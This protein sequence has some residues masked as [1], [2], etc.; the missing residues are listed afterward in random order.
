MSLLPINTA[1]PLAEPLL[2]EQEQEQEQERRSTD[3][4]HAE[5]YHGAK[6]IAL[7]AVTGFFIQIVSL[8][9]YAFLL[10]HYQPVRHIP[11]G[12]DDEEEDTMT[13]TT[14]AALMNGFLPTFEQQPQSMTYAFLSILTQV[15]LVVYV[16]IWVAFTC[17]M[18]RNGMTCIR[19]QF[20][21]NERDTDDDEEDDDEECQQAVSVKKR[22]NSKNIKRRYVFLLGVYFLVGIV[23]GA[24]LAWS[25]IDIYL[26][27]P[28][29][30]KPILLTVTVDLVLCYCMVRCYDMGKKKAR[31]KQL[32]PRNE[33]DDDD[34]EIDFS[35]PSH[36]GMEEV[37]L[38]RLY[39]IDPTLME[40]VAG[41]DGVLMEHVAAGSDEGEFVYVHESPPPPCPGVEVSY[42]PL[43]QQTVVLQAS[44]PCQRFSSPEKMKRN[45]N[46][47]VVHVSPPCPGFSSSENMIIVD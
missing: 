8:G 32:V 24:F 41:S 38:R 21:N 23:S 9:S 40:H 29:P 33:D 11:F 19:A 6:F 15:D 34:E 39:D 44:P 4:C 3:H 28:I 46:A 45:D 26:G 1:I 17:T 25:A 18:T 31:R 47:H 14:A 35:V 2:L 20:F 16:L 22:C 10:L 7:G 36:Q 13:T 27:F 5:H 12:Y 42:P 43:Y 37:L 30:F